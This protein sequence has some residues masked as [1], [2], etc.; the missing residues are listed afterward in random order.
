MLYQKAACVC[1]GAGSDSASALPEPRQGVEHAWYLPIKTATEWVLALMMLALA[2]PVVLVLAAV[3]KLT[4]PGP[5]FY[6]QTRLGR[7]GVAFSIFKIRSMRQDSETSTGPV[8]AAKNDARVTRIGQFMRETHIDELP[9]LWNV[10]TGEMSLIGPRPERP[11]IV[12]RIE[13]TLPHYRGRLALRPGLT[14]LAQVQLPAD[15]D[16]DDVRKKLAHDLYYVRQLSPLMDL[17]IALSTVLHIAGLCLNATGKLLVRSYGKAVEQEME[18][19]ETPTIPTLA[20]PQERE[21]KT[22]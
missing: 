19:A 15:S 6:R 21:V 1:T 14:G 4:S 9:Q 7:D 20:E 22:A 12:S 11:E 5:A 8:W 2:A 17:R 10:L 18:V 3:T 16:I 13:R